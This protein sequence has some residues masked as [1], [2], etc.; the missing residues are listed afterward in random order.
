M[1]P[2]TTRQWPLSPS[3]IFQPVRSLP[4][5]SDVNPGGAGDCADPTRAT[6][7]MMTREAAMRD[8]APFS[9]NL[10]GCQLERRHLTRRHARISA[11]RGNHEVTIGVEIRRVDV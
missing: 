9:S 3:G 5:K 7:S 4:L 2:S 10:R 11:R 1:T 8:M 6:T